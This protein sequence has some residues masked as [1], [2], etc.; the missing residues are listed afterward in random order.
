MY[1]HHYLKGGMFLLGVLKIIIQR[2]Y[3]SNVTGARSSFNLKLDM[4]ECVSVMMVETYHYGNDVSCR[5]F[6]FSRGLSTILSVP[7]SEGGNSNRGSI[8]DLVKHRTVGS[9]YFLILSLSPENST[10]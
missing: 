3:N 9:Y 4:M 8:Y 5:V 10:L 2:V 1:F 6:H 7:T